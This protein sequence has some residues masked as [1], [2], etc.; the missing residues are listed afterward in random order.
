MTGDPTL[1]AVVPATNDPPTLARCRAAIA[2]ARC[3]PE[4]TLVVAA[5]R[6][7]GP[8][9]AR[10]T[11][12]REATGDV[13]VFVDADVLVH[14]DAFAR[15]RA[16]LASDPN[17]TAL[18]GSY[19]DDP[20]DRGV[21]SS[22]RNLLHHHVHQSS[23]GPTASFWAGLGAVRRDAFLGV[24]G[25]DAARF[26]RPSVEDID[27]GMRLTEGGAGIVL[28]PGLLCTHLKAWTLRDMVR[29]DILDRG[30]PWVGLLI[31][32]R[33]ASRTLNL[34]WRHRLSASSALAAILF[35]LRRRPWSAFASFTALVGLNL[36]FYTLLWRRRGAGH[37][38]AGVLLHA[39]HH[40][41][42][43]AALP[44]GLLAHA[45]GRPGGA[46]V[47]PGLGQLADQGEVAGQVM[48]Q[49]PIPDVRGPG[50][51]GEL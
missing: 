48:L 30:V 45:I 11:G 43:A 4:E 13:L 34:G 49:R 19:D 33:S 40:V 41:C 47:E 7:D 16:A 27:L 35:G 3:P 23:A 50:I 42:A 29:T 15:I 21:V 6:A 18:F 25:F 20:E 31:A 12:A 9:A 14:R 38:L 8:A 32:R 2:A 51:T 26:E 22:F 28:D 1:T 17:L 44:L 36:S 46:Q 37:V 10:N 39:V 5:P 24:G